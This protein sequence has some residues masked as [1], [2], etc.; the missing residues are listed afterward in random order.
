MS[1]YYHFITFTLLTTSPHRIY[2]LNL[3]SLMYVY[4]RVRIQSIFQFAIIICQISIHILSLSRS[5]SI[6]CGNKQKII[7][8]RL[9]QEILDYEYYS[10]Y[11]Y[12]RFFD[13]IRPTE[14]SL[15]GATAD[16]QRPAGK[17]SSF[18]FLLLDGVD[19]HLNRS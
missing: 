15:Y 9:F 19:K 13:R 3:V 7:F 10:D 8:S 6:S 14:S 5:V 12:Y 2:I 18:R 4:L 16:S 1:L 17:H 11:F